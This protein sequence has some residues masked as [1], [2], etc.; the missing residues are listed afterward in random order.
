MNWEVVREDIMSHLL[1]EAKE[2]G[3]TG[4]SMDEIYYSFA[5]LTV[6]GSETTAT[7]LGGVLNYLSALPEKRRIVV[8]EVRAA[9]ADEGEITLSAVEERCGYLT[10]VVNEGLRLCPPV[11]WVLPRRVPEGGETVCGVWIPGG[12]SIFP[13]FL[14]PPLIISLTSSV[15]TRPLSLYRN[16]HSTAHPLSSTSLPRSSRSAG[17]SLLLLTPRPLSTATIGL[18][19][20]GSASGRELVWVS[21]LRGWRCGCVLRGYCGGLMLRRGR[22]GR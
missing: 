18:R 7:V 14:S 15:S 19:Y 4:M 8:D 2:N 20:R 1:K 10:A 16:T 12:V 6:A 13:P 11:P 9:F 3:S 21:I 5:G 17:S 22:V